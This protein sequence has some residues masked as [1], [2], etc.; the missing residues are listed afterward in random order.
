AVK[1]MLID[2]TNELKVSIQ[3]LN[4]AQ[5]QVKYE[6]IT[7][8]L[9]TFTDRMEKYQKTIDTEISKTDELD[10][11]SRRYQKSLE[12]QAQ[13]MEYQQQVRQEELAYLNKQIRSG[14]LT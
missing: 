2:R 4:N 10:Q 9:E 6:L 3:G 8:Q 5:N 13:F 1:D 14:N 7:A 12:R 11:S